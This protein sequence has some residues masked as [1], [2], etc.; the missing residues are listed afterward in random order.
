M[1]TP[2]RHICDGCKKEFG[3][4]E[5]IVTMTIQCRIEPRYDYHILK[6]V[7]LCVS[8]S[9]PYRNSLMKVEP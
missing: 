1:R 8:C 7:E 3:T 6:T 9:G 2:A 4:G 5:S